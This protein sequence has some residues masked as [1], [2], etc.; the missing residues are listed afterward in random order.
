MN[1]GEL[2][3]AVAKEAMVPREV[4]VDVLEALMGV[5]IQELLNEGKTSFYGFFRLY[6]KVRDGYKTNLG[7][8][9]RADVAHVSLSRNIRTLVR[10]FGKSTGRAH[11]VTSRNWREAL[12]YAIKRK[13]TEKTSDFQEVSGDIE[14][15]SKELQG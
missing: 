14:L 6:T 4:A 5:M 10:Y 12:A 1:K 2:V 13:E 8:V 15:K 7:W 11:A 9:P 3:K